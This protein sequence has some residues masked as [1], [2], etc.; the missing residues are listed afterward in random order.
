VLAIEISWPNRKLE[1]MCSQDRQGAARW[2]AEN[3]PRLK[4]RLAALAGAPTLQDMD[5]VP[6]NCHQLHTDRAG[7][8][9][10]DLWGSY[11]LVFEPDHDPLPKLPDGGI[12]RARVTKIVIREVVD[13]HGK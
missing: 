5:G 11:R 8:F 2:G 7:Q 10:V 3:W 6:G 1:K 12:D 4:R 9:A 13:Y